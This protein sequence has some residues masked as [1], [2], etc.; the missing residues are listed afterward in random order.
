MRY[1]IRAFPLVFICLQPLFG[2]GAGELI[3]A[4]LTGHTRTWHLL[5]LRPVSPQ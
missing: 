3:P 2:Q 4:G 5:I 1:L